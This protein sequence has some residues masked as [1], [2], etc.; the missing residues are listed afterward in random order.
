M[1]STWQVGPLLI[2]EEGAGYRVSREAWSTTM[3]LAQVRMLVF[4]ANH[5]DKSLTLEQIAEGLRPVH[6]LSAA[7]V[8]VL[9]AHLRHAMLGVCWKGEFERRLQWHARDKT[10]TWLSRPSDTVSEVQPLPAG[11]GARSYAAQQKEQRSV[12]DGCAGSP[13][14]AGDSAQAVMPQKTRIHLQVGDKVATTKP[15]P[16]F[17]QQTVLPKGSSGVARGFLRAP[18]GVYWATVVFKDVALVVA[19]DGV[20]V[21]ET[22]PS[23]TFNMPITWLRKT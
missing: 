3:T 1:V 16:H 2:T 7:G 12:L 19:P 9:A 14:H 17:G 10:Y 22:F 18:S 11:D 21:Q 5:S 20:S 4:L 15:V 13:G 23:F 8:R 6:D